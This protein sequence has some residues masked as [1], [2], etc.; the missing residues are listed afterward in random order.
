MDPNYLGIEIG[1][2]KLQIVIGDSH[3]RIKERHRQTVAVDGGGASIRVQLEKVIPE[4]IDRHDPEA[5]G[6]GFGGPLDYR[7]GRI[8]CSHQ[9]EGW[10]D[11]PLKEWLEA[12]TRL[13]V[14]VEN[15]ANTAALAE[16]HCGAGQNFDPVFY[17]TLGSG[18]GG[19]L[20]TASRVYHGAT[21][22]EAEIGHLRLDREGTTVEDRCSGW[23]MNHRLRDY[24]RKFPH[25][26]L[27]KAVC[28][29]SPQEARCLPQLLAQADPQ[30]LDLLD[31][32]MGDLAFGL[33]HV[34][35]LFHPQ[36][37]VVGGGLALIGEPLRLSLEK[38]LGPWVMSAFSPGLS[39]CLAGLREDAVPIGALILA[40]RRP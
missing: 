20:I 40:S 30:S 39:I 27:A 19:G 21:P 31:E 14:T 12:L 25:T 15:D 17:V 18:V 6:T 23:A 7:S 16:A 2:T 22:G 26:T 37:I 5:I 4:L 24:A 8:A 35:H 36:A 34:V 29:Q 3:G 1:G 13:P 28:A 9:I 32:A 11:F 38:Q 10:N 33:S